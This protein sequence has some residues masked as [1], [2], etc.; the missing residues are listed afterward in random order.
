MPHEC[1]EVVEKEAVAS[2]GGEESSLKALYG[3]KTDWIQVLN[4]F[5]VSVSREEE[6]RHP[7]LKERL[8]QSKVVENAR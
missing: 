3:R 7:K 4:I 1:R 2:F 8:M 5:W 6:G